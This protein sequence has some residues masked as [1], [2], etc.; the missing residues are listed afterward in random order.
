MARVS[1]LGMRGERVVTI[2]RRDAI[3]TVVASD[4]PGQGGRRSRA[5]LASSRPFD[6]FKT[7]KASE[8]KDILPRWTE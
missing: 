7:P 5:V 8:N 4:E 6:L 3:D 2:V 1:R